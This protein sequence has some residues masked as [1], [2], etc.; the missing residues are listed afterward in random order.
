MKAIGIIPARLQS[1]R[2]PN[3][4]FAQINGMPILERVIKNVIDAKIMNKVI[5]ATDSQ[6]IVK[7][8]NKLGQESFFMIDEVSCG[9]E[10]VKYI[11]KAF[12]DYDWYVSFPADEPMLDPKEL[13]K[14]WKK[15]IESGIFHNIITT[16]WSNFYNDKERLLSYK[17]CK[18]T[19]NGNNVLYFSRTPIPWSKNG[20]LSTDEYKKHIGI[21]IFHNDLLSQNINLWHGELA[22]KE[23]LEQIAFLE[24]NIKVNLI[25]IKHLYYGIDTPEDINNIESLFIKV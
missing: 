14:M 4:L 17:S 16:C 7:F 1:E 20:L 2:F 24:N 11:Y 23:G 25:E 12:P 22:E 8:C 5:V 19:S 9:S 6:E 3:K 13:I 21:F 18:I 10:R 15:H